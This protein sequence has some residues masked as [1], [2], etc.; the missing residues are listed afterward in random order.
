[1]PKRKFL[2]EMPDDLHHALKLRAVEQRTTMRDIINQA[3]RKHL[4]IQEGGDREK[5]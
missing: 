2:H 4:G 5:K 3:V 1:M